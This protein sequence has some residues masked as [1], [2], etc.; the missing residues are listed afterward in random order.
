[1]DVNAWEGKN[2][3][4]VRVLL[5]NPK[6]EK[7]GD[8]GRKGGLWSRHRGIRGHM[9]GR[10]DPL[11]SVRWRSTQDARF[12]TFSLLSL[13]VLFLMG[14]SPRDMRTAQC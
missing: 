6:W 11:A 2:P 3:G 1:M 9:D 14:M 7:G 8:W 5:A 12:I 10:A 4:G 13:H